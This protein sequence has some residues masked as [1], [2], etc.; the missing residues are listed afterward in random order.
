MEI[1]YFYA[2][3]I[4]LVAVT[5]FVKCVRQQKQDQKERAWLAAGATLLRGGDAGILPYSLLHMARCGG[6]INK[7]TT[8]SRDSW[9]PL[10]GGTHTWSD[11]KIKPTTCGNIRSSWEV[12]TPDSFKYSVKQL[13][14]QLS[15]YGAGGQLHQQEVY[16]SELHPQILQFLETVR[17]K[18]PALLNDILWIMVPGMLRDL[19]N[20]VYWADQGRT[21]KDGKLQ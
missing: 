14:A 1:I 7:T 10:C 12:R 20:Y 11:V 6:P 8:I 16:L 19:E 15:A 13:V 2:I 5:W 21:F 18:D 4:T 17:T 9:V 3:L